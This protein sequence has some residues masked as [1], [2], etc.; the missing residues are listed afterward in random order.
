GFCLA[1]AATLPTRI[2]ERYRERLTRLDEGAMRLL[3]VA[4][5][6]PSGDPVPVWQAAEL[7]GVGA[8]AAQEASDAGFVGIGA[9]VRFR[10]PLWPSAVHGAADRGERRRARWARAQI[11]DPETDPDRR[12]WHAAQATT[13]PDED[14]AAELEHSADR[15]TARGGLATAA[16]FLERAAELTGE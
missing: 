1:G 13:S 10:H 11:P 12:A 15:A 8:T 9:Q 16:A 3:P 2:E 5:L 14:V 4:A 6:E 7:L